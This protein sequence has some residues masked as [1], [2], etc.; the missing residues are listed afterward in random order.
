MGAPQQAYFLIDAKFRGSNDVEQIVN[1]AKAQADLAT[2]KARFYLDDVIA[3]KAVWGGV[4]YHGFWGTVLP[5]G[6][7]YNHHKTSR[8]LEIN[9]PK[10]GQILRTLNDAGL[11]TLGDTSGINP[12]ADQSLLEVTTGNINFLSGFYVTTNSFGVKFRIGLGAWQTVLGTGNLPAEASATQNF[13]LNG[14]QANQSIEV[15]AFISNDEGEYVSDTKSI[16]V[17]AQDLQI[18]FSSSM[19][20]GGSVATYY[21]SEDLAIGTTIFNEA[22]LQF[23]T[24]GYYTY[25]NNTYH[26]ESI[27]GVIEIT[28]LGSCTVPA[29][30]TSFSYYKYDATTS[31]T[32]CSFPG[33]ETEKFM[34]WQLVAGVK[35]FYTT[36]GGTTLMADGFYAYEVGVDT[37]STIELIDG[38]DNGS[39]TC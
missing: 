18:Q 32:A 3:F 23:A 11:N 4:E 1:P 8:L 35:R 2:L 37:F 31:S 12:T 27:G 6:F 34:F 38:F 22:T 7:N 13:E 21:I 25:G 19:P 20:C 10:P 15:Y 29:T 9:G 30:R 39:T 16:L 28:S 24:A 33:L 14:A 17:L 5:S 36:T 26:Q